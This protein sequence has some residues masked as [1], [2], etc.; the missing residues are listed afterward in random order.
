MPPTCVVNESGADFYIQLVTPRV[1][2][3]D[4]RML[5]AIC[6][7]VFQVSSFHRISKKNILFY[8]LG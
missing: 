2:S 4:V 8:V 3:I 6:M 5:L 1:V 7:M